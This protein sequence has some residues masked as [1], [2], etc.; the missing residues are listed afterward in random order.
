MRARIRRWVEWFKRD[1]HMKSPYRH[2]ALE[3]AI[4]VRDRASY[5]V[6]LALIGQVEASEPMVAGVKAHIANY[7]AELER[8]RQLGDRDM[9]NI[10]HGTIA[11]LHSL[12]D[13][14][15]GIMSEGPFPRLPL[16]IEREKME[17]AEKEKQLESH[18]GERMLQARLEAGHVTDRH[19]QEMRR[20]VVKGR[21]VPNEKAL[22]RYTKLYEDGKELREKVKETGIP[23]LLDSIQSNLANLERLLEAIRTELAEQEPPE[24]SDKPCETGGT[25][26]C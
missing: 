9:E 4:K 26:P 13:V 20:L 22:E 19:L 23:V 12:V 16:D 10:L 15:E 14:L 25:T 6:L 7:E 2:E 3:A 11:H 5:L 1:L 24:E 8:I 18:L 21:L 17:W